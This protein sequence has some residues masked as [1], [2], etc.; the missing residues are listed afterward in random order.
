MAN[1]MPTALH[2]VF[3]QSLLSRRAMTDDVLLE[4]YKRSI[5]AVSGASLFPP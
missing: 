5:S 3:N 2:R 1:V 4:M